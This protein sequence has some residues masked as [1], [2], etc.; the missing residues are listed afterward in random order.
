MENQ[1]KSFSVGVSFNKIVL[2]QWLEMIR[3]NLLEHWGLEEMFL[4][5]AEREHFN[6]REAFLYR[7]HLSYYFFSS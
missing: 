7:Q 6:H 4:E 1:T 3:N 5:V 2:G